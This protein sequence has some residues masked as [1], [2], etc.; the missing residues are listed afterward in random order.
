MA[1]AGFKDLIADLTT[2]F[3]ISKKIGGQVAE[4]ADAFKHALEAELNLISKAITQKKPGDAELQNL[5]APVSTAMG[6][7]GE[8]ESKY[9]G[10]DHVNHLKAVSEGSQALGWVCVEP[11]PGPFVK[12]TIGSSQFWS[13]KI[14]TQF[15]GKDESQVNW[16]NS[17]TGF[18]QNLQKYIMQYHTTGLAWNSGGAA[19]ANVVAVS[20]GGGFAEQ[21]FKDLINDHI[22]PYVTASESFGGEIAQQAKLFKQAV[23]LELELIKKAA[24]QKKPSQD[25]L[26]K[27][28]TPI[29]NIMNSIAEIESKYRG[30]DHVNHLKAV[31]EGTQALGWV[32]VEPTPGPFVKDTIG[33]SEFWSN[34]ILTQYKGKDEKQVNWVTNFNGFLK[35]LVPYIMKNHATGLS[36]NTGAGKAQQHVAVAATGSAEN[37]FKDIIHEHLTIYFT[38]SNKIGGVVAEQ[39]TLFKKAVE[40]EVE[41]VG[42]A[43]KTKKVSQDEFQKWIAPI[44]ETMGKVAEI[45]SKYRGKDHVNHLKTVSEGTQALGWVCVEPTPGPFVKDAI[46][47]S[48]FWSNKILKDF[49]G[50]DENQVNWV[51]GYNGFLKALATYIMAHHTTGLSWSK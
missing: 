22:V 15:K 14:L 42:K 50:K 7:V 27:E 44:S 25:D 32:C 20:G 1:E 29:S 31:S 3:D 41:L 47:S 49:K 35:N 9:R 38:E 43:S 37:D 11:T 21:E 6:K 46:G 51:K 19:A 48:E 23:D 45:E 4:Q 40:Q 18:L 33:S 5:L 39:A 8:I 26:M 24:G 10:K 30:K 16:V 12:D 28:V 36:W 13:N 2:Y 34:K 17:F